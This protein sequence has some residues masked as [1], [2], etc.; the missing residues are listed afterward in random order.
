MWRRHF[1][2]ARALGVG[3]IVLLIVGWALAQWPYLIAPDVVLADAAAPPAILQFVLWTLIPGL[4]L[5]I[6]SLWLL[7]SVFKG[8]I[9]AAM[10][11]PHESPSGIG[12]SPG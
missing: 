2:W 12:S 10:R 9:L 5:L 8:G 11:D 4:G 7:V 3:Q 6:P 1:R